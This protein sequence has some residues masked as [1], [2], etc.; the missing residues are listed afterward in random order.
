M[1]PFSVA[2]QLLDDMSLSVFSYLQTH[3][4]VSH[5]EPTEMVGASPVQLA[6]WEQKNFP[7]A[8]PDDLKRFLTT[9]NGLGVKWFVSFRGLWCLRVREREYVTNVSLG[10]S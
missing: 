7:C 5:L 1:T 3:Q 2:M 9:T 4:Y 10:L 6:V 8:L